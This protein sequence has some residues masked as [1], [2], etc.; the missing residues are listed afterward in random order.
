MEK[1]EKRMR[2]A[3]GKSVH[4]R[5]DTLAEAHRAQG[6]TKGTRGGHWGGQVDVSEKR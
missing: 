4:G 2:A 6:F 5:M 3:K 1:A